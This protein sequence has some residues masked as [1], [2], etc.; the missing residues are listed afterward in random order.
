[1]SDAEALRARGFRAIVPADKR[2]FFASRA[3]AY[4]YEVVQE[5]RLHD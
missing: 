2:D 5:V 1:M 4:G 3:E